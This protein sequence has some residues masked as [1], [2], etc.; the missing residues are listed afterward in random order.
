MM[1]IPS[2]TPGDLL[3][4]LQLFPRGRASCQALA[5]AVAVPADQLGAALLALVVAGRVERSGPVVALTGPRPP[6]RPM[7]DDP[8]ARTL[9]FPAAGGRKPA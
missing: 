4:A 3:F 1:P 2:P 6:A 8:R 5:R 7:A 9:R